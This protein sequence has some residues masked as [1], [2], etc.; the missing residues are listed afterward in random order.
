M[1]YEMINNFLYLFSSIFYFFLASTNTQTSNISPKRKVVIFVYICFSIT[2][3]SKFGRIGIIPVFCGVLF[4]LIWKEKKKIANVISFFVGY[5]IQICVDYFLTTATYLLFQLS[6][7]DLREQYYLILAF[8]YLVLLY[9]LTRLARH[10]LHTKLRIQEQTENS[11]LAL[12]ML[13]NLSICMF[14]FLSLVIYGDA[15]GYPPEM[16]SFNGILFFLY[17]LSSS[18]LIFFTGRTIQNDSRLKL[19]LVQYENL[20]TYT[21]EVERLYEEMR[22]F[23]HD[24]LDLLA[25]MKGYIDQENTDSL[26]KYFYENIMPASREIHIPDNR[27]GSLGRI[28]DEALKSL[29]AA[30]LMTAQEHGIHVNVEINENIEHLSMKIIDLIRVMGIFLT[31]ATEAA[32]KSEEKK[33]DL[34]IICEDHK[35][36]ILLGNSTVPLKLPISKILLKNT[37]TKEEHSGIGLH[38]AREILDKY[39]NV[40]WKIYSEGTYFTV[41]ISI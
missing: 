26:K 30:K 6:I 29:I 8:I 15:V 11:R 4:L 35:T 32:E 3:F 40:Q 7:D 1:M 14:I 16:V 27:L 31:N 33:L 38:T 28:K 36:I 12:M 13:I 2:L 24:Y 22:K 19:E 34:A 10:I 9:S 37:T 18:A 17:F 39:Q 21:R 41:R 25:S 5:L 23:R 20:H